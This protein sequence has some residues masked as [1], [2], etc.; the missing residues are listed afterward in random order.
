MRDGSGHQAT[1]FDRTEGANR[2]D[3][4]QST[5]FS[6]D[7]RYVVINHH[8]G[9][10]C[11]NKALEIRKNKADSIFFLNRATVASSIDK[12]PQPV[13]FCIAPFPKD[14]VAVLAG[15]ILSARA[16]GA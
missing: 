12:T 2:P 7:S 4:P 16:V 15:A 1:C 9:Y 11:R 5:L 14:G 6:K 3:S 10:K 8:S 13:L